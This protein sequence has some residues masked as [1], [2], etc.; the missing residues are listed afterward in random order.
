MSWKIKPLAGLKMLPVN[1]QAESLGWDILLSFYLVLHSN[2]KIDL[3]NITFSVT[4][5]KEGMSLNLKL[6]KTGITF[7]QKKWLGWNYSNIKI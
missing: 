7:L 5:G 1:L 2:L 4:G 6:C 3:K